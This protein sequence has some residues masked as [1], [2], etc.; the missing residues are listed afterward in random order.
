MCEK[1]K[2]AARIEKIGWESYKFLGS[3][4]IKVFKN[5]IKDVYAENLMM[6][7]W[8]YINLLLQITEMKTDLKNER[9]I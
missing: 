1:I 6:N 4:F 2:V 9:I 5:M 3:K 8:R 7:E